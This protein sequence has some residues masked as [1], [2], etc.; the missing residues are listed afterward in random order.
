VSVN[1]W[2]LWLYPAAVDSAVPDGVLLTRS[3][4]EAE[5]Q[6]AAGGRV[7]FQPPQAHLDWSCPPL[8]KLPVFWN[9]LM[10][11]GWSR[12]LGLWCDTNHP[13]L[14]GFP[15]EGNCDWQWTEII[16]TRAINL[17]RLPRELSPI[18][19]AIDD[20]NRNWK[21]GLIFET[22]VGPGRLLVSAFDLDADSPV[23][24]QLRRSLL[25]Y[26]VGPAFE[27]AGSVPAAD[28]RGMWFDTLVMRKL[29]AVATANS[30]EAPAA[31]DGDPNTYW[32]TA[33]ATR[34][35]AAPAHPHELKV[36]FPQPVEIL[37]VVVM[38]RQNDRDHQ[39]DIANYTLSVGSDGTEWREVARG[40]LAS[41]WRPQTIRL[42]QPLSATNLKLTALSGH[43]G[44][45]TAAVAE[46]AVLLIRPTLSDGLELKPE[47][48]RVRSTSTDIDEGDAPRS[49]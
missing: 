46:L 13:A 47:Y 35:A 45:P 1:D 42:N 36:R 14:A 20:W 39:G 44:D 18:V 28:L 48:R 6:L 15:T 34:N 40:R 12:M 38:N 19:S 4:D 8:D 26:A 30:G 5:A 43:G 27:P 17:D 31:I 11:P 23:A 32:L 10:G 29:G 7:V 22:R 2:N 49:P 16:K 33:P 24:R 41:T 21:L 9:R 3:W 25:D 37:G